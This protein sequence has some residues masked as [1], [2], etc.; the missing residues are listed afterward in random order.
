MKKTGGR[1]YRIRAALALLFL[2]Y[3]AFYAL[4]LEKGFEYFRPMLVIILLS[5]VLALVVRQIKLM[6]SRRRTMPQNS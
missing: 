3:L 6:R 2:A 4:F 5:V 1:Y